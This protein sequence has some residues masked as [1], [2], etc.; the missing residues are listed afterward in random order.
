MIGHQRHGWLHA[1]CLCH[2]PSVASGDSHVGVHMQ[3]V[4]ATHHVS[5]APRS[6]HATCKMYILC[7]FAI[8]GCA[9][10]ARLK[11]REESVEQV[12]I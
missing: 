2:T 5:D 12:A 4:C 11:K 1:I 6:H 7:G 9:G 8:Y 3:C 10:C